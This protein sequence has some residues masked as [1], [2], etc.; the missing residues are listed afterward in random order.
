[1]SVD[2]Q[3]NYAAL[4]NQAEMSD[5][6]DK[7][8]VK[9]P[10]GNIRAKIDQAKKK[11]EQDSW[12][13]RWEEFIQIY[14]NQ[15]PYTELSDYE[16]IVVPNM[17]FSTVNVIEPSI[18]VNNPKISV[19]AER[20]QDEEK[21]PVIEAVA[22]HW[23]RA[24]DV[25]PEMRKAVKDFV[26][27]GHGWMKVGWNAETGEVDVPDWEYEAGIAD[28][29]EKKAR[30]IELD[31]EIEA[32]FDDD[33]T[34]IA[35]VP[36]T[37]VKLVKDHPTARR[38]SP[39]DMFVDP[40]ATTEKDLRWIAQRSLVPIEVALANEDYDPAV[41][42]KLQATSKSSAR[43]NVDVDSNASD[44][45]DFCEIWEFYNLL[46]NTV[47][48][49]SW[50]TK[51]YLIK[52]TKSPFKHGHPFVFMP[53]FEV[54]ERF[55][56][57][58]DVETIFPL[59]LELG[60]VRSAQIADRKRGRRI[61]LYR[62]AALGHQ[63]VEDLR[64]GKDNVMIPVLKDL[65]FQ[66]V[67]AQIPALGLPPEWYN[68]DSK[69]MSDMD[70]V[71]GVSEYA[72]GGQSEVRRTAT[73][74][75]V[76]QD[77]AN[78]KSADKLDKV[79]HYMANVAERMILLGQEFLE[80]ESVARMTDE[81]GVNHW[82]EFSREDLQGEF[83]FDVEAGSTSPN[84]ESFRRQQ[85]STLMQD[86]GA[87]IGSGLLNDQYFISQVLRLNGFSNPTKFLG[88]GIPPPP[89]PAPPAPPAS[90][91]AGAQTPPSDMV[92]P[93]LPPEAQGGAPVPPGAPG[94]DAGGG[95]PPLDQIPPELLMQL[96]M[97]LQGG[98][99]ETPGMAGQM[100]AAPMM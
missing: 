87:L 88:P 76:I 99:Q 17:V 47:C 4:N 84:N 37:V 3:D 78:A 52:P 25:Q 14:S 60:S 56:P 79:Y 42:N 6:G 30:A 83:F 36:T 58:G 45:D 81:E 18:A 85:A 74:V 2:T 86:F 80:M 62:E 73:E 22:N 11:R 7:P 15:Y 50:D 94:M 21:A 8:T 49:F 89:P 24:H 27:I 26:I 23:W 9:W 91:Q 34:I 31:P 67:F 97:M 46:D 33:D 38:V 70:L 39:F 28:L 93:P 98:S 92:V 41:R 96:M 82:L 75:G 32:D 77:A 59:Q 53:N 29:L 54:P 35:S 63:G 55:F 5:S 100:P 61:T 12:D 57:V 43:D 44:D 69:A 90:E 51:G 10:L 68:A 16:D 13:S 40:D 19:I 71:S 48:T 65:P 20:K 66:D 95:M 64:A 72:R 1:M